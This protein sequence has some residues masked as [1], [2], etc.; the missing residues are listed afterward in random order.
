[1]TVAGKGN[2]FL[3]SSESLTIKSIPIRGAVCMGMIEDCGDIQERLEIAIKRKHVILLNL[4]SRSLTS[5]FPEL[6]HSA[7]QSS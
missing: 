3:S 4:L 2:S 7:K 6:S 1:M 5:E